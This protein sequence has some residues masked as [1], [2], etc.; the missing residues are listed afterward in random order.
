MSNTINTSSSHN[1]FAKPSINYIEQKVVGGTDNIDVT[2]LN[3]N[4][5]P[6]TQFNNQLIFLAKGYDTIIIEYDKV[7]QVL[8]TRAEM[9]NLKLPV[10]TPALKQASQVLFGKQIA[11]IPFAKY[12]ELLKYETE[13]VAATVSNIVDPLDPQIKIP[14]STSVEQNAI[15]VIKQAMGNYLIEQGA[16]DLILT[17]IAVTNSQ[18]AASKKSQ[19]AVLA[20]RLD[21][22]NSLSNPNPS[23]STSKTTAEKLIEECLPCLERS[24]YGINDIMKSEYWTVTF[25]FLQNNLVSMLQQLDKIK[26]ALVGESNFISSLCALIDMLTR[27]FRCLPDLLG[28]IAFL[29]TLMSKF[30]N[31]LIGDYKIS[32]PLSNMATMLVSSSLDALVAVMLKILESVLSPIMCIITSLEYESKKYWTEGIDLTPRLSDGT[33]FNTILDMSKEH[34]EYL[35]TMIVTYVNDSLKGWQEKLM[36][37]DK[38]LD[39]LMRIQIASQF[40]NILNEIY[41]LGKKYKSLKFRDIFDGNKRKEVYLEIC[42]NSFAGEPWKNFVIIPTDSKIGLQLTPDLEN[43]GNGNNG[44]PVPVSTNGTP[45]GST[46]TPGD[47]TSGTGTA[48]GGNT[49]PVD[50]V[51]VDTSIPKDFFND[52]DID[53]LFQDPVF[54]EIIKQLTNIEPSLEDGSP[55]VVI[56]PALVEQIKTIKANIANNNAI[57]DGIK[58]KYVQVLPQTTQS[59]LNTGSISYVVNYTTCLENN[60][61]SGVSQEQINQWI[62]KITG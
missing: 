57:I 41:Q 4:V 20:E 11:E 8:I 59:V 45:V 50:L 10:N 38:T 42:K 60:N 23:V 6:L 47:G 28:F 29:N 62:R 43:I 26:V 54:A 2:F 15:N 3:E 17:N 48:G 24:L 34:M 49:T 39:C 9:R 32:S 25:S 55:Q 35:K 13:L 30:N 37:E 14:E 40:V 56:E 52:N 53:V 16:Q 33:P 1:L 44:L 18:N 22:T 7:L 21:E 58:E 12:V 36:S 31:L 46:G 5:T 27:S 61:L 19:V 51:I